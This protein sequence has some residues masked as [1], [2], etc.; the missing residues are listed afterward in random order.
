MNEIALED[1]ISAPSFVI[2]H[3]RSGST[4]LR[5]IIDTHSQICCPG[6]LALGQLANRLI[7]AL[8]RTV[9]KAWT[10]GD[11]QIATLIG[12]D[13]ARKIIS[14]FMNAYARAKGKR[15]WCEKAPLNLSYLRDLNLVF[16]EAKYICLYRNCLDVVNSCIEGGKFGYML[17]LREYIA[18][19]PDNFISA[20]VK[21]WNDK[22]SLMLSLQSKFPNQCFAI[23]YEELVRE[24]EIVLPG[25]FRFLNL[26]WENDIISNVFTSSHDSGGGDRKIVNTSKISPESVGKGLCLPSEF[27]SQELLNSTNSTLSKLGYPRIGSA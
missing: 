10:D 9:G 21:S 17:E 4:L 11:D 14:G 25:L 23:K 24:P 20:M 12:I 26:Y 2:S 27:I 8:S 19:C 6:E 5:Y 7:M 13:E 1:P 16:P 18:H 22:T 15:M 3:E